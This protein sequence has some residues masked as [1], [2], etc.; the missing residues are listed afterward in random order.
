LQ[1][2]TKAYNELGLLYQEMG[3]YVGAR[4]HLQQAIRIAHDLGDS[5]QEAAA[6]TSLGHALAALGELDEAVVAYQQAYELH[7]QMSQY[8]R[9]LEPLAGLAHLAAQRGDHLS[10]Q[11]M[12]AQILDHLNKKELYRTDAS[13]RIYMT[14]YRLLQMMD[15][16]RAAALLESAYTQLQA[17]SQT[18]DRE[19][20]RS[21]FWSAPPHQAVLMAIDVDTTRRVAK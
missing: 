15:D 7:Q 2:R 4:D 14:C 18:L 8:S 12:V 10:V 20:E 3:D 17:R 21:L 1:W 9:S 5:R 11:Q 13:L 19:D 16:P 6:H